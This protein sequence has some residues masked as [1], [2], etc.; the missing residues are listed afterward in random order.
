MVFRV[1]L[2]WVLLAGVLPAEPF[3]V[4]VATGFPPYQYSVEGKPLGLD[5]E[6]TAVISREA[7]LDLVWDQRPWDDVVALLRVSRDLEAVAGMEMTGDRNQLFRF[8]QTLYTRKNLLFL[9]AGTPGI[10]TLEDLKG[11]AVTGDRDAY[12]EEVLEARGL[13]DAVRLVRTDSK[14]RAFHLLVDGRVSAAIMPEAVGWTLARQAG[15]QV[16][17]LDFGDPGSP[18]AL[19]FSPDRPD[20]LRRVDE[21]ILKLEAEGVLRTILNRY[22]AQGKSGGL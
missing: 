18:V 14:E 9:L 7:G 21:A 6:L 4:G 20:L 11:L 22:G 5:V 1:L 10:A 16:R 2:L 17:A 19:A 3:R 15:V 12:L 8:S 13:K